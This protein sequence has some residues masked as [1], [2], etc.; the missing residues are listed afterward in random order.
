MQSSDARSE[1][2]LVFSDRQISM[3]LIGK[4]KGSETFRTHAESSK[5][6]LEASWPDKA[7][8]RP[9][10]TDEI[11]PDLPKGH[12]R[13]SAVTSSS[14]RISLPQNSSMLS[15]AGYRPA[16]PDMTLSANFGAMTRSK[17]V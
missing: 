3:E 2:S 11:N 5:G 13:L 8:I 9:I 12:R 16:M 6:K 10:S 4:S 17:F 14:P 7:R 1:L 15:A